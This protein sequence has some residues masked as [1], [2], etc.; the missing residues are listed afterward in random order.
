MS[1]DTALR[2][3]WTVE[4]VLAFFDMPFLDLLFEAQRTHRAHHPANQVQMAQ[5]LSIKTGGCAEDCAYCPQSAKYA[6]ETG[7]KAEKL[8]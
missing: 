4:E 8:M 5:L 1:V 7:L 3:D 6:A 2:H